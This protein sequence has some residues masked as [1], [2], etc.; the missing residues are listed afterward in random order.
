MNSSAGP[1]PAGAAPASAAPAGSAFFRDNLAVAGFGDPRQ[2]MVT[3]VKEL[4]ENALDSCSLATASGDLAA[5]VRV[6][7]RAADGFADVC[8]TDTGVGMHPGA[9]VALCTQVYRSSKSDGADETRTS[10]VGRFGLG[11]KCA[12]LWA[13]ESCGRGLRVATTRAADSHVLQFEATVDA[14]TGATHV[15]QRQ[16]IPKTSLLSGTQVKLRL[17]C[18]GDTSGALRELREY[19]ER[20]AL[21]G[22]ALPCARVEASLSC[23]AAE[24]ITRVINRLPAAADDSDALQRAAAT[25]YSQ[26]TAFHGV[27]V[28]GAGRA[29][30]ERGRSVAAV[31]VAVLHSNAPGGAAPNERAEERAGQ[32]ALRVLRTI[33]GVPILRPAAGCAILQQLVSLPS[34]SAAGWRAAGA[35]L[36]GGLHTL[37]G[38]QCGGVDCVLLRRADGGLPSAA[39]HLDLHVNVRAAHPLRFED[40]T[41]TTLAPDALLHASVHRGTS[42]ALAALMPHAPALFTSPQDVQRSELR[43]RFVPIV[44]AACVSVLGRVCNERTRSRAA[45]A[46]EALGIGPGDALVPA[47]AERIAGTLTR[48][49][50]EGGEEAGAREVRTGG[51]RRRKQPGE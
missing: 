11:L 24:S 46:F 50:S 14:A 51:K 28:S 45:A 22:A 23:G 9:A 29:A 33:N 10:V 25:W 6:Q 36:A 49:H 41:K 1:A 4:T 20:L 3:T 2:A 40:L 13:Q 47:L 44:A 26:T 35:A 7:V 5:T 15:A 39:T 21:Q 19:F 30:D 27:I 38:V 48:A 43:H 12:L 16:L 8:I 18:G 32:L 34:W 31:V 42:A 37:A 17:A